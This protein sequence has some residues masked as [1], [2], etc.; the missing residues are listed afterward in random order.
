MTMMISRRAMFA[1]L[2]GA[3]AALVWPGQAAA[4]AAMA[5][6]AERFPATR[7]F[8]TGFVTRG[9][10]AGTLAAIGVGEA[11]ATFVG[12]GSL[13][14]GG[15]APVDGDSLWRIYSMT[16]PVTG[17]AAMLLIEDGRMSLDQPLADF[18]PKFANM[19]VQVTPDGSLSDVRPAKSP[20]TIRQLLTHTAGLGYNIIQKGP[21]KDAYVAA[22]ILPGQVS[23]MPLPG[24]ERGTPAPSLTA[25]ADALAALP[26]VYEPGTQWSYSVSLDLLGRVIEVASGQPFEAFLQERLF[27]PLGMTSTFFQVPADQAHRLATNYAPFGGTLVA[28]DPAATSIYRDPP[29]FAMGGAGLVASA[30]DYDRFLAMLQGYGRTGKVRVMAEPTARLAMSNLLDDAVVRTGT[31]VDGQGHGAGGRVSLAGALGGAGVFGWGGAAG[32]VA[33][34]DPVRGR[35]AA[36][37]AQYMP[38]ETRDFQSKLPMAILAD[39][40]AM[41][42]HRSAPAR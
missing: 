30:R 36:G 38:P 40:E 9:E 11:P 10:L 18:L 33:F 20:I 37:Y 25:F 5:D 1:G 12:A 4:Y 42:V 26:L 8:I 15:T 6:A 39:L 27:G 41:A 28:I 29:P 24:L 35:R 16:K 23:R 17:I 19:A 32:T 34:V 21:I 31:F 3:G 2:A 22:G 7:A 13:A 14:L